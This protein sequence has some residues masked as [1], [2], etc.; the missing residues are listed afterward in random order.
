MKGLKKWLHVLEFVALTTL[1][2]TYPA[3]NIYCTEERKGVDG[4]AAYDLFVRQ[5]LLPADIA[6]GKEI[7][8]TYNRFGSVEEVIVLWWKNI[9]SF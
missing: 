4:V 2:Q 6:P 1:G 3:A 8:C 9:R 7:H 5:E